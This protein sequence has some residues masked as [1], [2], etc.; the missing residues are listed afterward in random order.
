MF[1]LLPIISAV[2][3]FAGAQG[4]TPTA[5]SLALG[6]QVE[7]V[8]EKVAASELLLS[9]DYGPVVLDLK[10]VA[11]RPKKGE[12]V[13]VY[14]YHPAGKPL[15]YLVPC[16]LSVGGKTVTAAWPRCLLLEEFHKH[17]GAAGEK[18]Q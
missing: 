6:Y 2:A 13:S 7:G 1:R 11:L 8:V 14:G 3:L 12:R 16:R 18:T 17:E 9:T 4:A 5:E 15:N 10:K